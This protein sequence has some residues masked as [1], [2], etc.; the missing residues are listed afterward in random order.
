MSTPAKRRVAIV[1]QHLP[2]YREPVFRLMSE[3]EDIEYHFLADPR[4][5]DGIDTV[6]VGHLPH[7]HDLSNRWIGPF[8]VQRGLFS[9][10]RRIRPD[11][12][13][14]LGDYRYL[15]TWVNAALQR[16]I[17]ARVYF[18]TQGW[19]RAET[20][21][22]ATVR[23]VFYRLAHHL[24][25]YGS[26]SRQLGIESGFSPDRITV[27][28]NSQVSAAQLERVSTSRRAAEELRIGA[29]MRLSPNKKVA[30]LAEIAASLTRVG[31]P[32]RV[33]IA[34][35]GA[36]SA[37]LKS[38]CSALGVP[39]RSYGTLRSEQDLANFY[40]ELDVCVIPGAA[41]LSVLQALSHG[42]PCV[43]NSNLTTQGPE[44]EAII[45]ERTGSL[46]Q[47]DD[48]EAFVRS[49]MRWG[50]RLRASDTSVAAACVESVMNGWV[51]DRQSD[52]VAQKLLGELG[53]RRKVAI[54]NP[55]ASKGR[56]SGPNIF[57]DRL[58]ADNDGLSATIL[59]GSADAAEA[60]PWADVAVP[61]GYDRSGRV[62]QVKWMVALTAWLWLHSRKFD[63]VH[64]HG[65]Y[66]FNLLPLRAAQLRGIPVVLVPLGENAELRFAHDHRRQPFSRFRRSIVS[67]ASF[68]LGLSHKTEQEL[69]DA[70]LPPERVAPIGNPVDTDQFHPPADDH[71]LALKTVGFLGV[72][73][74]RK[75]AHVVLRAVSILTRREGFED[76]RALFVGPY[77]DQSY[78]STFTELVR[79]LEL[80][81]RVEVTGY[82]DAVADHV[83]RMSV[84]VLPSNQEGLPGALV[85]AMA[86]GLPSIVTDVGAMGD[87]VREAKGG[88]VTE[89][90]SRAIADALEEVM[91]NRTEWTRQSRHAR[92]H[93]IRNY[94]IGSVQESYQLAI[95]S[96]S[97]PRGRR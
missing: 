32:T 67:H 61:T 20:G 84:F 23:S 70:G 8:L 69:V 33:H 48:I 43:T 52:L 74:D 97:T 18:W 91:R 92:E 65:V 13:I 19:R 82:T 6:P 63:I 39:L 24:L 54:V 22:R 77:Y 72:L 87:A 37:V 94:S 68:G 73:G 46:V 56:Y 14:F 83:R 42:R 95:E 79:D 28:G 60:Y 27:I 50:K 47:E 31:V 58:F 34:G 76:I 49:I 59:T 96:I 90:D 36:E 86:S 57:M 41:G 35:E 45:P 85:E 78:E 15:T 62:A 71:R 12:V 16:A 64:A 81:D 93:A 10:L 1:Y 89:R 88:K 17:G 4:G 11:A 9:T 44:V 66:L 5:E 40:S 75:G 80:D 53:T 25:V 51:A 26:R 21:L 55:N 3:H 7:T 30:Q 29:V 38:A 2:H